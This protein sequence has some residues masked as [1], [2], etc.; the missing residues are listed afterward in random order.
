MT[1]KSQV[2]KDLQASLEVMA[3]FLDSEADNLDLQSKQLDVDIVSSP[4]TVYVQGGGWSTAADAIRS[5][6]IILRNLAQ[7]L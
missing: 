2:L 4:L 5:V 1:K 7:D 3:L 6:A